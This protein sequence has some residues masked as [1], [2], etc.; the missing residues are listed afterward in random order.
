LAK[1][2]LK[3]G[4]YI[5]PEVSKGL[6]GPRK[7][8]C[9]LAIDY[10]SFGIMLVEILVEKGFWEGV[11]NKPDFE[12]YETDIKVP[13][14]IPAEWREKLQELI[15]KD[16]QDRMSIKK[17][18]QCTL[19]KNN[20]TKAF[21]NEFVH[22]S[23]ATAK[24]ELLV[25]QDTMMS[26]QQEMNSKMDSVLSNMIKFLP[27]IQENLM[28]LLAESGT[29]NQFVLLPAE[30]SILD[31]FY[32]KFNLF[33]ICECGNH[34]AA[35]PNDGYSMINITALGKAVMLLASALL[36]IAIK[37]LV[38][39]DLGIQVCSAV[40]GFTG[41]QQLNK[42]I[43]NS[44]TAKLQDPLLMKDLILLKDT[45]AQV[46]TGIKTLDMSDSVTLND[47]NDWIKTF[48]PLKPIIKD[49]LAS[50]DISK[51]GVQQCRDSSG[52]VLWVCKEHSNL[53]N[54]AILTNAPKDPVQS[55]EKRRP[56]PAPPSGVTR[57][58]GE[59]NSQPNASRINGSF[60]TPPVEVP[61]PVSAQT[62]VSRSMHTSGDI[63]S[64]RNVSP[65]T[66]FNT[67]EA[68]VLSPLDTLSSDKMIPTAPSVPIKASTVQFITPPPEGL[69]V[70]K[71]KEIAE[72]H[73]L[74]W[75]LFSSKRKLPEELSKL[76][77]KL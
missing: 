50:K 62:P 77:T 72:I 3:L 67:D 1:I 55:M 20:T 61:P 46:N 40:N 76:I 44:I 69:V 64:S 56:A 24:N 34:I 12:S 8:K 41:D 5:P 10:F 39:S 51:M 71:W 63:K 65:N 43:Q 33:F 17:F 22:N 35:G 28:Q 18:S 31:K 2:T 14:S 75:R 37:S 21:H 70:T 27:A 26:L 58:S 57:V 32:K 42:Q 29:P 49:F 66:E 60:S 19:F 9:S 30:K 16:P 68:V 48:A 25:K 36:S 23:I 6:K 45:F 54:N 7:P 15:S 59:E 47:P 73:H 4:T 11:Y 13:I 38:G 52:K 74:P 53:F